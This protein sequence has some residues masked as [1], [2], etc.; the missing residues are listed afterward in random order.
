MT[1]WKSSKAGNE[2]MALFGRDSPQQKVNLDM[3]F[4]MD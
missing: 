2:D 3:G 1:S 4:T